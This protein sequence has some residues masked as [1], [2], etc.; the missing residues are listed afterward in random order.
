MVSSHGI[1]EMSGRARTIDRLVQSVVTNQMCSDGIA[2]EA[3]QQRRQ[4]PSLPSSSSPLTANIPNLIPGKRESARESAAAPA[5]Q[6]PNRRRFLNSWEV[7]RGFL[8]GIENFSAALNVRRYALLAKNF[9][10]SDG[11]GVTNEPQG[12]AERNFGTL[13]VH[14]HN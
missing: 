7:R 9:G 8:E 10:K 5:D 2:I 14:V 11:K 3:Q 12:K 6:V 4:V 1:G 13:L